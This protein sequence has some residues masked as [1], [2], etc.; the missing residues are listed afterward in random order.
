[1]D[2]LGQYMS[3]YILLKKPPQTFSRS[4]GKTAKNKAVNT[5]RLKINKNKD[6]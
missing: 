5:V 4:T 2:S 1:M 3:N 6:C